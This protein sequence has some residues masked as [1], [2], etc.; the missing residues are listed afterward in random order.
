MDEQERD[1]LTHL[2]IIFEQFGRVFAFADIKLYKDLLRLHEWLDRNYP[3][4]EL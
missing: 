4:K 3:A 1:A 2:L